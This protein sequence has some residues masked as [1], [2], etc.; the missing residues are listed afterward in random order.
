MSKNVVT[1][2]SGSVVTQGHWNSYASID[3]VSFH[4][5]VFSNFIPKTHRFWHIRLPKFRDLEN[6]VKSLSRSLDMSPFD[7]VHMTSYWRYIVTMALSRVVS[8]VF[9]VEKCRDLD[10]GARGH[11][12]LL[13]V[14][15]FGRSCMVSIRV[16]SLTD[17]WGHRAIGVVYELAPPSLGRPD[18]LSFKWIGGEFKWG[19]AR[20]VVNKELT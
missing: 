15:P 20:S 7:R 19:L 3:R 4:I 8:E 13:K 16:I 2:K 1:L 11:S 6:Q 12:R 14:V 9:N 17:L 18:P 5:S 10:I